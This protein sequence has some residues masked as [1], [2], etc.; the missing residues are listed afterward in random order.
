MRRLALLA[1]GAAL[2]SSI[3]C[4]GGSSADSATATPPSTP[5]PPPPLLVSDSDSSLQAALGSY[6]WYA[7]GASSCTNAT[8]LLTSREPLVASGEHQLKASLPG[9]KITEVRVYA[10]LAAGADS[11]LQAD[12]RIA[13]TQSSLSVEL[14][15]S[16]TDGMLAIDITPMNAGQYVVGVSLRVENRGEATY[17]FLLNKDSLP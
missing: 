12:G 2:L 10:S 4:G 16:I 8:T 11:Q 17:G 15:V 7:K 13:W 6:C 3:A 14:P 5:G 1:I 9:L